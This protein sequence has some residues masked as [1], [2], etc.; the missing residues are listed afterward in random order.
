M[1]FIESRTEY[2]FW[3][4]WSAPLLVD[5]DIRNMSDEKRSILM[6]KEV[7]AINQDTL[8]TAGDRV[9]GA[10]GGVQVWSRDL[11]NGD[12][13]V[14]L[15]NSGSSPAPVGVTWAQLNCTATKY[16]VRDLWAKA[17]LGTFDT[18]FNARQPVPSKD[19]LFLRIAAATSE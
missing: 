9:S 11:A 16:T 12:K 8:V 3:A 6:N 1:S 7:I 14:V 4:L 2:T 5:T 13:A 17:D 10:N 19:V 18:G 15:F